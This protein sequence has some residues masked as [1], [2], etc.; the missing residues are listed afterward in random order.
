[1]ILG[2][3]GEDWCKILP[4]AGLLLISFSCGLGS[5]SCMSN[6]ATFSGGFRK[7][8]RLGGAIVSASQSL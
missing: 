8:Q 5:L 4:W 2:E 1:M 6:Q 7:L 3:F